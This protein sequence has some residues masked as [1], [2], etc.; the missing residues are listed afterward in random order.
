MAIIRDFRRKDGDVIRIH[1]SEGLY[2]LRNSR[3]GT[4]IVY[5]GG[6]SPEQIALVQRGRGLSLSSSAFEYVMALN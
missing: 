6:A 5:V 4:A 2:Q 3:K 1:G